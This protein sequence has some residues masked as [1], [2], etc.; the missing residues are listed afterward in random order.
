[1]SSKI[2]IIEEEEERR[3]LREKE[4]REL[5]A[6]QKEKDEAIAAARA[7]RSS[8]Y[9][10]D[11]LGPSWRSL[12]DDNIIPNNI[13]GPVSS[14]KEGGR[15]KR[16]TSKRLFSRSGRKNQRKTMKKQ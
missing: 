9:K 3:K 8:E 1:M 15:K 13:K 16:H 4:R 11:P 10:Q 6:K 2:S 5:K 12:P 14:K 7:A